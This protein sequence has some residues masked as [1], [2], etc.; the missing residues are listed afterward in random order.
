MR[1]RLFLPS[2]F[3]LSLLPS[4]AEAGASIHLLTS[5]P[6]VHPFIR[7]IKPIH[8]PPIILL[9]TLAPASTTPAS[10]PSSHIASFRLTPI[11]HAIRLLLHRISRYVGP[12][13]TA[14]AHIRL[15]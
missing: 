11:Y 6:A 15:T 5:H 9:F 1:A 3:R 13:A 14:I 4:Q 10:H 2:N 8:S 12:Y 7:H